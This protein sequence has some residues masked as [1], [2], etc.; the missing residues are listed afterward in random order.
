MD[1]AEIIPINKQVNDIAQTQ[2]R[3]SDFTAQFK[4]RKTRA[5][6]DLFEL[7]GEIGATTE[8]PYRRQPCRVIQ[9]NI[10]IITNGILFLDRVTDQYYTVSIMSGNYSFFNQIAGL[11]ISD[12][13]LPTANHTWDAS[14]M[15]DTHLSVSP[16]IDVVYPLC[17]PSEDGS[18]SPL[19]DDGDRVEMY[20]G[21]IWCFVRLRTIWEEIFE[22]AGWF[23]VDSTAL[24]EEIF[25]KLYIPIVRRNITDTQKISVSRLQWG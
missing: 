8:F 22:N 17:E 14:F 6:R 20:G 10:E 16:G 13:S 7:S 4:I 3:N 15:A 25:S 23:V 11:K 5:M 1:D 24:D 21:W 19:T 18:I 2:D 9:D 12:L